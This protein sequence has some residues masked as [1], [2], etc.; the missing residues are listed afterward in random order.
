MAGSDPARA[1]L[2]SPVRRRILDVLSS[3]ERLGPDRLGGEGL[4]AAQLAKQLSLHVTTVR[5][6]LDQLVAGGLV[7]ASF[8]KHFG[9]GR[10]R[11]VYARVATPRLPATSHDS[12]LL[13]SRLL[14]DAFAEQSHTQRRLSPEE[15]GRRWAQEN[16]PAESAEPA[17]TAGQW[18]AKLGRAVDV[19]SDWGYDP[20]ITADAVGRE[21]RIE[22]THCPFRELARQNPV[23]VCGIHQGL[24]AGTLTRLG[25]PDTTV[26]LH[27]FADGDR[28]IARLRSATDGPGWSD[29]SNSPDPERPASSTSQ[30][31]DP[32]GTTKETR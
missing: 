1:L 7:G 11:K 17:T 15:A 32:P 8:H 3:T 14:T 27:P 12:L 4:T 29:R 21:A 6:H 22:L 23:V 18:I 2:A 25:E 9:A 31:P 19:L 16:V 5:F 28:C 30:H 26:D 13:L 10:P 24:I 20:E